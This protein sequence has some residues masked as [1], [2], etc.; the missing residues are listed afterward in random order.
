MSDESL[1]VPQANS[2]DAAHL[3]ASTLIGLIPFVGGAD[4]FKFII[5]PS[6]EKR[7]E[8]WMQLV[9]DAIRELQAQPGISIELLRDNEEFTT[10]LMQTT[11]AA[12]KTHLEEKH[13]QLKNAVKTALIFDAVFDLKQLYISIIDR[14][15]P[16]HLSVLRVVNG[17]AKYS[18]STTAADG[19]HA[20]LEDNPEMLNDRKIGLAA[21]LSFLTDLQ[22]NGLVVGGFLWVD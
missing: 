5:S 15:S 16:T 3:V 21:F 20:L 14:L 8:K 4:L 1:E 10:L 7:R 17:F 11:Q 13:L 19:L 9:T 22:Q 2:A 18:Y 12:Y 6:L